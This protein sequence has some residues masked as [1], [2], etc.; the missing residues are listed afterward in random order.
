M[1]R[2]CMHTVCHTICIHVLTII[3]Q[4][5]LQMYQHRP[6]TSTGT[7]F[8]TNKVRTGCALDSFL[9][10]QRRQHPV[11]PG[12]LGSFLPLVEHCGPIFLGSIVLISPFQCINQ[13]IHSPKW[14][15]DSSLLL[16][17]PASVSCCGFSLG[18]VSA[19]FFGRL[20]DEISMYSFAGAL[21]IRNVWLGRAHDS[22]CWWWERQKHTGTC[23]DQTHIRHADDDD[24]DDE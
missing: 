19:N 8:N 21:V 9:T 20:Q 14:C 22:K 11:E 16:C 4:Y 13:L 7:E 1:H 6:R 24:D 3:L 17:T 12:A 2:P 18:V 15:I 23:C 10:A 5:I